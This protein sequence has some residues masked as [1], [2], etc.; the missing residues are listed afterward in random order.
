MSQGVPG[1]PPPKLFLDT[2]ARLSADPNNC[3]YVENVG[4]RSLREAIVEEMKIVYGRAGD[5]DVTPD[6]VAITA[7][8][9]LAFFAS[10]MTIAEK[11]DEVILPVPW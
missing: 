6:D 9:N 11:G 7:G 2:L 3:G 5:V 4:E 1:I 10:V 8:C